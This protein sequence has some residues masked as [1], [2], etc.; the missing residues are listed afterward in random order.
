[1]ERQDAKSSLG[2]DWRSRGHEF[3]SRHRITDGYFFTFFYKNELMLGK[4]KMNKKGTGMSIF[5]Q[6][7][8]DLK[9]TLNINILF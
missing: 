6:K 1:M 8:V 2:E 4:P 9:P 5:L 7:C 3:E